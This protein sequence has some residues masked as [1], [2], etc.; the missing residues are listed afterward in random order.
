MEDYNSAIN[1]SHTLSKVGD[2]SLFFSCNWQIFYCLLN[3]I[4]NTDFYF[5]DK[6]IASTESNIA[7]YAYNL[8]SEVSLNFSK[9]EIIKELQEKENLFEKD[10]EILE[11]LFTLIGKGILRQNGEKWS[12]H[13]KIISKSLY[14]D[15]LRRMVPII[16]QIAMKNFE[17][18]GSKN[19]L[20]EIEIF[21]MFKKLITSGV[22]IKLF[23]MRK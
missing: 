17:K 14:F 8:G 13:R 2:I 10:R 4:S 22:I 9:P 20:E 16:Q 18:I 5:E 6:V 11:Y 23:S 7:G 15:R 21:D 3:L 19:V 12:S 1:S